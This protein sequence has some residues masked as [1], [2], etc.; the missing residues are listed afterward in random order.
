MRSLIT[1]IAGFAGGHL[2]A[3]LLERSDTVAGFSLGTENNEQ[4][5]PMAEKLLL[6][7]GDI[8]DDAALRAFAAEFHPDTIFHLAAVTNVAHAWQHRRDT[9]DINVI[10]TAAVLEIAGELDPKPTVVIASSGQIYG[11]ATADDPPFRED[12]PPNP[13]GPYAVSKCCA[14]VLAR[15][16]CATEGLPTVI[17]RTFNYTGAW[18]LPDFVCSD[19]ARQVAW[20]EAGLAPAEMT[21]GNLEARRDF[22]D[23]RDI[24]DGYVLAASRGEPGRVYNLA[25]GE[26]VRIGDVLDHLLDAAELTISVRQDPGRQ[27]KADLSVLTGD[28]S[29]ARQELGWN[30]TIPF[31]E[32]VDSVLEFW[33]QRAEV[34]GHAG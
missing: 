23:V 32:T 21:V 13:Q 14:E 20:A 31:T 19:F 24:V 10:G 5:A 29:R 2:A 4:L 25:S 1:G 33:R 11:P 17:M 26:A 9:L 3:A 34:M 22:T 18:Q 28:A 6:E 27:R 16:A 12:D 7:E 30:P 8:R 15:Q